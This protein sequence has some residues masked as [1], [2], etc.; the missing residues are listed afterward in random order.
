MILNSGKFKSVLVE[1]PN[2]ANETDNKIIKFNVVNY[3]IKKSCSVN[4]PGIAIYNKVK[5]D[6]HISRLFR[7]N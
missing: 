1:K 5:F 6:N 4:L 7:K 2:T 3:I